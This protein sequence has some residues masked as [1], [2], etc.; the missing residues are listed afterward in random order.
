MQLSLFASEKRWTLRRERWVTPA[1]HFRPAGY[2]V[3]GLA[4]TLARQYVQREHYSGTFPA[5]RISVGLWGPGPTLVGT[6]VFSIPMSQDVLPRW[7]GLDQSEAV[8]LGRFVCGPTVK[9]NGETW[10][11]RRAF[12]T[13]VEEKRSRAVLSFADPLE[14]QTLEGELT[15]P[16]HYG[17]IYQA[18]GAV[19]AGRARPRWIHLAPDG[20]VISARMISKIRREERGIG[21]AVD[22]LRQYGAPAR[23]R[24][25]DWRSWTERVL[26]LP[27]FRRVRHPGNYAYV[28]GL[29]GK[30][31]ADVA[32]RYD[33]GYTYPRAVTRQQL[34]AGWSRMFRI[35]LLRRLPSGVHYPRMW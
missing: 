8:E 22:R 23:Q 4:E 21:Y 33:G 27:I 11:L 20:S 30:T 18:K 29:D 26:S 19:F 3:D 10:F 24:G 7:T 35:R 31:V 14:R 9:F 1:D 16:A 34:Q 32:R 5:A 28:F 6:A 15:K 2:A 17:T 13:L 25:E 12:Q